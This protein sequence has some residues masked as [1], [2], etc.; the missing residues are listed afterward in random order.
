LP[1]EIDPF[2]GADIGYAKVRVTGSITS[3]LHGL[4][5]GFVKQLVNGKPPWSVVGDREYA[6]EILLWR[7][8]WYSD[9]AQESLPRIAH[10]LV[11]LYH[12]QT[13]TFCF[14]RA[15]IYIS[16]YLFNRWC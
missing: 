14:K 15:L 6:G 11:F 1:N 2:A 10:I 12:H 9:F 16:N 7:H 13:R 5:F 8:L 3:R 4:A